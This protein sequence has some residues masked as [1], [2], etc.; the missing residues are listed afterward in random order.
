[1]SVATTYITLKFYISLIVFILASIFTLYNV[2]GILKSQ[3]PTEKKKKKTYSIVG[4]IFMVFSGIVAVYNHF[5][6]KNELCS[7]ISTTADM[8]DAVVGGKNK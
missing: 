7:T 1:M 2:Y 5:C 6:S 3:D 8:V 4:A